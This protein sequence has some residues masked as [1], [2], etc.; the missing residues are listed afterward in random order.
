M[1]LR[2]WVNGNRSSTALLRSPEAAAPHV[3]A[4]HRLGESWDVR[5]DDGRRPLE[6]E[7]AARLIDAATTLL[8]ANPVPRG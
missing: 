7:L 6:P 5:H 2:V 4:A 8:T 3:V 1:K